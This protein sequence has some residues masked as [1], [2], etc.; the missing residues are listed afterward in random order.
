MKSNS[1]FVEAVS[2]V[3]HNHGLT[4]YLMFKYAVKTDLTRKYYERRLKRFFDFIEFETN[5]NDFE[6]RCN[7]FAEKAISNTNWTLSQV[8][9]FLQYQKERVENKEITT[10][11]LNNFVKSI[12]VFCEMSDISIP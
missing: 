8:I 9:R 4:P 6:T 2:K 1:S 7:T 12:K 11:T 3:E 5:E 10:A